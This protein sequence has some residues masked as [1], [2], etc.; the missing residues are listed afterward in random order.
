MIHVI[1]EVLID[2]IQQEGVLFAAKPGGAPANVAI[3]AARL[4]APA[5][6]H[7]R[8]SDD[9]FGRSLR[10]RLEAEG[11]VT[12]GLQH[13]SAPTTLAIAH[14]DE[15][16]SAS[17]SFYVDGTADWDWTPPSSAAVFE[18]AYAVHIGS[19]AAMLE[20]SASR[21]LKLALEIHAIGRTVVSFDV[22]IRPALASSRNHERHRF[23]ALAAASHI[24]KVSTDDL[25]WLYPQTDPDTIAEHLGAKRVVALTRGEDGASIFTDG[26]RID[27]QGQR[28]LVADTVAAGDTFVAAL[29]TR[30]HRLGYQPGQRLADV[31]WSRV[32]QYS[33][34]AA[35]LTCER[36]GAEPPFEAEVDELVAT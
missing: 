11:V 27:A 1:G 10:Q 9:A 13:T 6:I 17:Y 5:A 22:N 33:V 19:L 4:G 26:Q 36:I 21:I 28:V 29:L 8:G 14:L 20:P 25:E 3:A 23:E 7:G 35:A 2:L 30:L 34:G 16:G 31:E 24:V 12:S 18:D 32:L 15:R